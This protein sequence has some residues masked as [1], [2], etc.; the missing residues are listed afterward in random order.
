MVGPGEWVQDADGQWTWLVE[1]GSKWRQ[2][3]TG[4]W[5]ELPNTPGVASGPPHPGPPPEGLAGV[6]A[7][8][9]QVGLG[10]GGST[11]LG[12]G[13]GLQSGFAGAGI[14]ATPVP[15][16]V[17]PESIPQIES[18]GYD[19]H[20]VVGSL[21]PLPNAHVDHLG[22]DL[23]QHP[24]YV[25]QEVPFRKEIN[26]LAI[27]SLFLGLI[28]FF[29]IG[30]VFSII[31]GL[32]ARHQIKHHHSTQ[33]GSV[34]AYLGIVF[35]VAWLCTIPILI[36]VGISIYHGAT[37]TYQ[38]TKT[39]GVVNAAFTGV[40]DIFKADH[41][42]AQVQAAQIPNIPLVHFSTTCG[43]ADVCMVTGTGFNYT[44]VELCQVSGA[45]RAWMIAATSLGAPWYGEASKACP[46]LGDPGS[47]A[48]QPTQVGSWHQGGFPPVTLDFSILGNPIHLKL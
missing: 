21:P 14:R 26:P 7:G 39:K 38:D 41:N 42:Y 35:S 1:D 15:Y 36:G 20:A 19:D 33:R 18:S 30:S 45:G 23:A 34:L 47:A 16:Q 11:T 44:F 24:D 6:G 12:M 28:C 9:A 4:D 10:L 40:N 2:N 43:T 31:L 29:Y 22:V 25:H 27:W 46:V 32:E 17:P 48:G 13:S 37:T 3:S 8:T 5:Y